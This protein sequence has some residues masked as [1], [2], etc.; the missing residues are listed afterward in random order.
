[1]NSEKIVLSLVLPAYKKSGTLK[2]VLER[3]QE[4]LEK[5]GIGDFELILVID[6]DNDGSSAIASSLRLP[7]LKTIVFEENKGKGFAVT[8]GMK[9]AMGDLIGY[10][11]CD[12]DISP[13]YVVESFRILESSLEYKAVIG[14]KWNQKTLSSIPRFRRFGSYCFKTLTNLAF[15]M[16]TTDSQTGMKVFRRKEIMEIIAANDLDKKYLWDL[17][18]LHYYS[19][20]RLRIKEI[21]VETSFN[22]DSTLRKRDILKTL[23]GLMK[24]RIKT[25]NMDFLK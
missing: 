12:L 9:I 18:V 21:P 20:K 25:I 17:E 19:K 23:I 13:K 10:L 11:D 5:S 3:A 4:V 7:N 24:L 2:L 6:G 1:M 15:S 22:H 14:S 16:E 8:A